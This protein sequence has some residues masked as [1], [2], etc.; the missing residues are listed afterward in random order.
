M[1]DA[2]RTSAHSIP[3]PGQAAERVRA[4]AI[5]SYEANHDE[6]NRVCLLYSGGLDTS[7]MLKWI[8]DEY[9]AEVV[10]LTVN[11]GQPGEDY[12]VVEGKAKDLGAIETHVIVARE[13]FANDFIVPA[14]PR[15]LGAQDLAWAL[16]NSPAFLFNH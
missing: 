1:T 3:P 6:V 11:L 12:E 15:A 4:Q 10:T 14:S 9:E 13:E 8:Q 16:M 5:A 2:P 7:V